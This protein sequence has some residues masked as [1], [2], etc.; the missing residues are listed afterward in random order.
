M[1]Q[2]YSPNENTIVTT[3]GKGSFIIAC[4]NYKR[5]TYRYIVKPEDEI[6]IEEL[7]DLYEDSNSLRLKIQISHVP[8]GRYLL[9][10]YYVNQNN[11]SVQDIWM[12][13]GGMKSLSSQEIDYLQKISIPHVEMVTL[14]TADG[15]LEIETSLLQH[16]IKIIE[17]Q[18]QY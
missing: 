6:Q 10:S 18:Y 11:G 3:N 14:Q 12:Q 1:R 7:N 8:E 13:M 17:V 16:E 15:V 4:H 2:I 9:K 5:L